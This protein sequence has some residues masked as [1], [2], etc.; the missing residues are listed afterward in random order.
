LVVQQ[1]RWR[2]GPADTGP[3]R[4]HSVVLGLDGLVDRVV[5]V[6]LIHDLRT[7]AILPPADLAGDAAVYAAAVVEL[8][9]RLA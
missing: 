7:V 9:A 8:A 4:E 2:I 1:K 6:A 5:G 3:H